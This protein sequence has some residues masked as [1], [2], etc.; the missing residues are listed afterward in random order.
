MCLNVYCLWMKSYT[1]N[2]KNFKQNEYK[3][4]ETMETERI[5]IFSKHPMYKYIIFICKLIHTI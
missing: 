2:N 5:N 1:W 4:Y 3:E